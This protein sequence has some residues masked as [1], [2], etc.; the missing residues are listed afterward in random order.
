MRYSMVHLY[1]NRWNDRTRFVQINMK[2]VDKYT[3]FVGRDETDPGD[4]ADVYG[5][6]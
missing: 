4:A 2:S 6:P 1:I 3:A 5:V